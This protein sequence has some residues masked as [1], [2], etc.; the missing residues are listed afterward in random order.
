MLTTPRKE[1]VKRLVIFIWSFNAYSQ[2]S[3]PASCCTATRITT[4]TCSTKWPQKIMKNFV[5]KIYYLANC[6]HI[7]HLTTNAHLLPDHTLEACSLLDSLNSARSA[8]NFLYG[9]RSNV[10]T[11]KKVFNISLCSKGTDHEWKEM[12]FPSKCKI[13]RNKIAEEGVRDRMRIML[14]QRS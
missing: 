8:I 6:W 2:L 11:A 13:M 12:V 1:H 3:F 10:Q 14:Q 9:Q 7:R 5:S 4:L